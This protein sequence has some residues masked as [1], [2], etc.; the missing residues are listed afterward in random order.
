MAALAAAATVEETTEMAKTETRKA[1]MA[2]KLVPVLLVATSLRLSNVFE[3]Q[4]LGLL[5]AL[6][7]APAPMTYSRI[8]CLGVYIKLFLDDHFNRYFVILI[9]RL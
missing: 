2:T 9:F 7:G 6:V 5:L 4:N 8:D 3:F 1:M